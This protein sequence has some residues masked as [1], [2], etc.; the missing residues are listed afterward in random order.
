M[1]EASRPFDSGFHDHARPRGGDRLQHRIRCMD[2]MT[3]AQIRAEDSGIHDVREVRLLLLLLQRPLEIVGL[4]GQ[5]ELFHELD[6]ELHRF[7][8]AATCRRSTA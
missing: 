1:P 3:E 2:E 4:V 8:Q 5:A 7:E 6:V